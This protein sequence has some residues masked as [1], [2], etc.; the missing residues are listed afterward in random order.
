MNQL[1]TPEPR[2]E[3]DSGNADKQSGLAATMGSAMKVA[4]IGWYFIGSFLL[5]A[6]LGWWIDREAGCSP[7]GVMIGCFVGLSIGGWL[8]MKEL[9]RMNRT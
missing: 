7:A 4:Q 3:A 9:D 2:P 8:A 5:C 1:P 6:A